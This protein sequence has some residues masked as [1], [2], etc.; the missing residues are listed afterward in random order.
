VVSIRKTV[1]THLKWASKKAI[2]HFLLK[3]PSQD[4][5][6]TLACTYCP[7]MCRFSCPVAVATGNDAVTP[8]GMVSLLY[9][10]RRWPNQASAGQDPWPLFSCTGCGRCTDY[11][12]HKV[13]V[14]EILEEG[15]K[16]FGWSAAQDFAQILLGK[17]GEALDPAGDHLREL[18]FVEEA[19]SRRKK[20]LESSPRMD[21]PKILFEV[22]RE[23]NGGDSEDR[24][25]LFWE[26]ALNHLSAEDS[27]RI[28]T[29]L[30]GKKWLMVESP[31]LSRRLGRFADVER[32][33]DSL[34]RTGVEIVRP[35]HRGRD[36]I[37][38][39][40]ESVFRYLFEKEAREMAR[41]VWNRD[42][43]RAD[44]VLCFSPRSVQHLQESLEGVPVMGIHELFNSE[45]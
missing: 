39:G 30:S 37:D 22:C 26:S 8:R 36:C 6:G 35:F 3:F 13:P 16:E 19:E 2:H 33:A 27:E 9:K 42:A 25:V 1:S 41:E 29:R 32:W 21:E 34:S 14:S 23:S 4:Q 44:G 38:S 31:W 7:E 24:P 28:R 10:E 43:H 17:D 20:Y 18:G 5:G 12:V 15:R 11:C 40:G 45:E